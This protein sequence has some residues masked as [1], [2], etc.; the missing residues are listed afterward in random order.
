MLEIK[1]YDE[2]IK[3]HENYKSKANFEVFSSYRDLKR[4]KNEFLD[5][6]DNIWTKDM[7]AVT[8]EIRRTGIK[9]FTVSSAG[10][11]LLEMLSDFEKRGIRV[12]GFRNIKTGWE[13]FETHEEELKPAILMK[14]E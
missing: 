3:N 4:T 6:S 14:V 1:E 9:E 12:T 13:N 5:F 7:D 11:R 8:A 2:I 10:T